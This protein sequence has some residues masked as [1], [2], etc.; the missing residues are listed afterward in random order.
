M[1][2]YPEID[3]LNLTELIACFQKTVSENESDS[4]YFDEV[5]L[6]I[7]QQ[8]KVGID[9]LFEEIDKTNLEQLRAI[10]LALTYP[11]PVENPALKDILISYISDEKTPIVADVVDGL[12]FL[13]A[14]DT[15]DVVLPLRNHPDPYIRG[16]V[17]R[18][19]S[20]LFPESALPL[21]L[22][23]LQDPH[24]IVRENSIDKLDDLGIIEAIPYIRPFLSDPH[25]DVR[26]AAETA[27]T[28]LEDIKGEGS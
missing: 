6:L 15:V 19:I 28:N 16:S 25:P 21:L 1:S 14:T 5:A 26:Q 22:E 9:F 13:G 4:I 2:V 18:F 11:P 27:I 23:A 17:L 20:H 10:I 24:Y 3:K 7:R 12:R 8:G